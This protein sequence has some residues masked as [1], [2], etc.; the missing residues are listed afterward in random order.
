MLD[1]RL[2]VAGVSITFAVI[3]CDSDESQTGTGGSSTVGGTATNGDTSSATSSG[4]TTTGAGGE[5]EGGGGGAPLKSPEQYDLGSSAG[6]GTAATPG[7]TPLSVTIAGTARTY[8]RLVPMGYDETEPHGLVVV[9]HGSGGSGQIAHDKFKLQNQG[10]GQFIFLYPDA[11]PDPNSGEPRWDPTMDSDDYAFFDAIVAT[12]EEE[13]CIDRDRLFVT[14]FSLGA[15]F[16]S[17]LGCFRGDV[18]RAIAPGAPGMNANNLP[19][20]AE[21]QAGHCRGEVGAWVFWGTEDPD[22]K[23]GAELVRDYYSEING[24]DPTRTPLASPAGCEA[25]D[26]CPAAGPVTWCTYTL[27]HQWPDGQNVGYNGQKA[28]M[29]FFKSFPTPYLP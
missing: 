16:T 12:A 7:L 22:H 18:I 17:M 25:Y 10:A 11:L 20:V 6:C 28:A 5:G 3:A 29:D 26:N 8:L 27:N 15:R 21:T 14:G 13:L 2:F 23:I 24:C 19:L 4:G 9:L 1:R